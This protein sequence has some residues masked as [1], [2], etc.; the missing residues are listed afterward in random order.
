MSDTVRQ[1][2]EQ[3]TQ[4]LAELTAVVL[5][6]PSTDLVPLAA[7]AAGLDLPALVGRILS[8]SQR[9]GRQDD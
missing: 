9:G 4:A 8:I 2:A 5:K 3:S 7:A 1:K 6:E